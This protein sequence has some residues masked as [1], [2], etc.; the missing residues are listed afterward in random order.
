MIY[1]HL[2]KHHSGQWRFE[3]NSFEDE[4]KKWM[5]DSFNFSPFN[6]VAVTTLNSSYTLKVHV[7]LHT[8]IT[9]W[10]YHYYFIARTVLAYDRFV[11]KVKIWNLKL[12]SDLYIRK[13]CTKFLQS[14]I[15]EGR[16]GILWFK[17]SV[18]MN[19][20]GNIK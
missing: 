11:E 16:R 1:F 12:R 19:L 4:K 5:S 15:I 2:K 8:E 9:N 10:M 20:I 14:S 13:M 7:F 18:G 6:P 3:Y 17:M